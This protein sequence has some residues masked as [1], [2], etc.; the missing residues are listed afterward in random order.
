MSQSTYFNLKK[1]KRKFLLWRVTLFLWFL[2][3]NTENN[4]LVT[5]VN[6]RVG[7]FHPRIRRVND[8][9]F[10]IVQ[11]SMISDVPLKFFLS[12][13][14]WVAQSVKCPT[15]A[16]VMISQFVSSSPASDSVLTAQ[17]PEPALD[18]VS[19]SLCSS[20]ALTLSLSHSLK[21]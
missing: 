15:S 17:S 7:T 4:Q 12:R 11:F 19:P 1:K 10:L 2:H 21:K 14:T 20:P 18:S 9:K 13:G 3:M 8:Y 5:L 6:I 16:Q